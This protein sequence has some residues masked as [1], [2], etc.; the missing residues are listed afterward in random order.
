MDKVA[1]VILNYLNYKDTIECVES[2]AI[3]RYPVKEIIVVD[4]GSPN[5]SKAKLEE[6]FRNMTGVHFVAN[7]ENVG[8]ARGNNLGIRYATEILGC[9][10]VLLVNNDTLFQDPGM[11]TTLMEAYEPGVGVVG[12]RIR[13]AAGHEQNP[14]RIKDTVVKSKLQYHRKIANLTLKQSRWYQNLKRLKQSEWYQKLRRLNIFRKRR[15]KRQESMRN[16]LASASTISLDLVLH[17]A[18][19]LL[20]A[21]Y[22]K[23]YPYL[24]PGT[25]LFYE[26]DILTMLTRKVGLVKKFIHTTYI[27]H[28]EHKSTEISFEDDMNG[29]TGHYYIDSLK[30]A[31]QMYPLDYKK[32]ITTYFKP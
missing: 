17:G 29:K 19:F 2:I 3:D 30:I 15:K 26:E 27:F 21:D 8:F 16:S 11:I 31:Q 22:F 1:I 13:A 25:F 6:R 18:C 24:F 32:I 4:N 7:A 9:R 28:K 20:T 14:L 23:H 12:P 10:F 5:D